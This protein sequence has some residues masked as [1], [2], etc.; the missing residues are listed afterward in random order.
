MRYSL[1]ALSIVLAIT[2]SA[3]E[4]DQ[5]QKHRR[6]YKQHNSLLQLTAVLSAVYHLVHKR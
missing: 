2:L 6:Q 3:C 5:T 1:K 4:G